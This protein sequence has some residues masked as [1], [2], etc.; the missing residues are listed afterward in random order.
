[1]TKS[2]TYFCRFCGFQTIISENLDK[3][4]LNQITKVICPKCSVYGKTRTMHK[5]LG[6]CTK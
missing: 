6:E 5:I 1:M 2:Q 3:I 4:K